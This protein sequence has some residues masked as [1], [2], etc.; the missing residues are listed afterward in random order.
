MLENFNSSEH[1]DVGPNKA[2]RSENL[3]EYSIKM[4]VETRIPRK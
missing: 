2:M 4:R 1:D 3:I